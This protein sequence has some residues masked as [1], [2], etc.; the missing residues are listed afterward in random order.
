MLWLLIPSVCVCESQFKDTVIGVF[1]TAQQ[2]VETLCSE[3]QT[4]SAVM[5]VSISLHWR[6]EKHK[7]FWLYTEMFQ[8]HWGMC[9]EC[10]KLYAADEIKLQCQNKKTY[11]VGGL[12]FLMLNA[13]TDVIIKREV[14]NILPEVSTRVDSWKWIEVVWFK[15]VSDVGWLTLLVWFCYLDTGQCYVNV[16]QSLIQTYSC[17]EVCVCCSCLQTAHS[18][19]ERERL[20]AG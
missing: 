5:L 19:L 20:S 1:L 15:P 4:Q 13:D 2:S 9:I 6:G 18:L 8:H 12:A 11:Q 3:N 10:F 14:E 7:D 16:P 17:D